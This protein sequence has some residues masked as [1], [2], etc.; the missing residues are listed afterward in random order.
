MSGEEHNDAFDPAPG[1]VAGEYALGT[2]TDQERA[3]AEQRIT[4]DPTF[5]AEVAHWQARL[6]PLLEAIPAADPP[7]GVFY[8]V[9]NSLGLTSHDPIEPPAL[10]G[11]MA[12]VIEFDQT[13]RSMKRWRRTALATGAIAASLLAFVFVR[14][15]YPPALNG[16]DSYVAVLESESR[17]VAFVATINQATG[18]IALRRLGTS[19]EDGHSHELW[20]VGGGRAA[21]QSLGVVNGRR[22][23][24]VDALGQTDSSALRNTVF[25]ISLEPEGGSPTGQP[26]GPVIFTGKLLPAPATEQKSLVERLR[27]YWR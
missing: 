10:D 6:A 21:P 14:E 16:G 20:A 3:A 22:T 11:D 26:T 27:D 25:A 17:D 18:T 23:L 7:E 4:E 2:L 1:D 24:P 12:T 13:V 5:A 9:R 15:I 19:A 8:D